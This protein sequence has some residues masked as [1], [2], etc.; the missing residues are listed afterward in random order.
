[1]TEQEITAWSLSIAAILH[2]PLGD[3]PKG[4]PKTI[5]EEKQRFRDAIDWCVLTAKPFADKIRN[6]QG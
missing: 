5:V 4:P 6:T 3:D 2:G 1:M